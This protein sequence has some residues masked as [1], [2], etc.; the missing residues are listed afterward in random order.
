MKHLKTILVLTI[1]V[2]TS[3][4]SVFFVEGI[5][6]PRVQARINEQINRALL[7]FFPEADEQPTYEVTGLF[8]TNSLIRN[9]YKLQ[10]NA[11]DIGIFYR[12]R[13]PGWIAPIEI[14][15]GIDVRTNEVVNVSV[16]EQGETPGI[17]EALL[18]SPAFL[19]Q[20]NRVQTLNLQ[21][22]GVDMPAGTSAPLTLGRFNRGVR[23][24]LIYH[25]VNYLGEAAPVEET[26]EEI[27]IR[28]QNTWFEGDSFVDVEHQL[29]SIE[30]LRRSSSDGYYFIVRFK[31]SG[32]PTGEG[33]TRFMVGFRDNVILGFEPLEVGD[34]PEYGGRYLFN[35][36]TIAQFTDREV[37]EFITTGL[38]AYTGATVTRSAFDQ[39]M[40]Q[41]LAYY[42]TEILEL[43]AATERAVDQEVSEVLSELFNELQFRNQSIKQGPI[44]GVYYGYDTNDSLVNVVYHIV[45]DNGGITSIWNNFLNH[46]IVEIDPQTHAIRQLVVYRNHSSYTTHFPDNDK[47]VELDGVDMSF[48]IGLSQPGR[49]NR[50]DFDVMSGASTEPG[51]DTM[52]ALVRAIDAVLTYQQQHRLGGQ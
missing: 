49:V 38:D 8:E 25:A 24:I 31:G 44:Y 1:V 5:T 40:Y 18:A 10:E 29:E 47:G 33:I 52:P 50:D 19:A 9:V 26:P 46:S 3:M 45:H 12:A 34:T 41:I 20:F 11:Q 2:V 27:I 15:I 4:M 13:F 48:L 7:E 36:N 43:E 6:T 51:W 32:G 39:T 14:L 42:Q 16:L 23:E 35:R 21:E 30:T 17:G 22:D 28:L 37:D